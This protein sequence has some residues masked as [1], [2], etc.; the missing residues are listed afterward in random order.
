[1]FKY[2]IFSGQFYFMNI[3]KYDRGITL[4][5]TTTKS[6]TDSGESGDPKWIASFSL[7]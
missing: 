4:I 1:M 5:L 3:S 7:L 2:A 6:D